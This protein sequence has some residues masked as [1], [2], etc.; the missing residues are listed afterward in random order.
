M[1]RSLNNLE[2]SKEDAVRYLH[3]AERTYLIARGW[4]FEFSINNTDKPYMKLG[5][6]GNYVYYSHYDALK[7]QKEIDSND[8]EV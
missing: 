8:Q 4:N 1:N 5:P 7:I 2:W 3:S 6:E